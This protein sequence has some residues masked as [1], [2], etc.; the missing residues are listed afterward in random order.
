MRRGTA[1]CAC[2]VPHHTQQASA[3]GWLAPRVSNP[4]REGL[5]DE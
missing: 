4:G 5:V 2:T 3:Q 1:P